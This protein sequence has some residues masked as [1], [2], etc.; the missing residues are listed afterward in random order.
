MAT[1]N[2]AAALFG[3]MA[4]SGKSNCG[5][6]SLDLSDVYHPGNEG[7][8]SPAMRAGGYALATGIGFDVLREFWPNIAH[9]LHMPFRDTREGSATGTGHSPQ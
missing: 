6:L 9:K 8:L 7:G 3:F 5:W 4:T 2:R 1:L